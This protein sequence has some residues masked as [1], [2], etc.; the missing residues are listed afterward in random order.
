M[1]I[2]VS[3]EWPAGLPGLGCLRGIVSEPGSSLESP[4]GSAVMETILCVCVCVCVHG[5]CRN[6][7]APRGSAPGSCLGDANPHGMSGWPALTY[8]HQSHLVRGHCSAT[9]Q[10]ETM[11]RVTQ[12][13]GKHLGFLIFAVVDAVSA[14]WTNYALESGA[15]PWKVIHSDLLLE[16]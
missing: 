4:R 6:L 2:L 10:V 13:F 12:A 15:Y 11:L 8:R 7:G 5:A 9:S 16:T 3:S 14:L 1:S